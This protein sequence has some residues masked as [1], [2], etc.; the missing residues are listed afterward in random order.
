MSKVV[1]IHQ[2]NYLPWLG[3]FYKMANCDIFVLLDNVLLSKQS[4]TTRCHIKG[5]EGVR[6]LPVPLATKAC[7]IHE[8]AICCDGKWQLKHWHSMEDAYRSSRHW[9]EYNPTFERI[10]RGTTWSSLSQLNVFLITTIKGMLGIDSRIISSSELN[11]TASDKSDRIVEICR[12]LDADTY[13]SGI[14]ARS[15]NDEEIFRRAGV[16]LAYS[17]FEHPVYRQLWGDFVPNLSIVDLLFNEGPGSL[18]ILR[19]SGKKQSK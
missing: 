3:Y 2:P 13:L 5:K 15:Y 12:V 18:D 19:C 1:A 7:R 6:I 14:G 10:Y 8:A 9:N 4:V 11:V 17:D 16:E